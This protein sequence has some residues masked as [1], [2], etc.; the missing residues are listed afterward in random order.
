MCA[1][2]SGRNDKP[3]WAVRRCALL[4]G[5]PRRVLKLYVDR[6]LRVQRHESLPLRLQQPS[7]R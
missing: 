3:A 7:K 2:G 1:W 4:S 5:L 6:S